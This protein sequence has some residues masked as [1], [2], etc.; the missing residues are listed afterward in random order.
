MRW[1]MREEH[2]WVER[3]VTVT[4]AVGAAAASQSGQRLGTTSPHIDKFF[5]VLFNSL[6]CDIVWHN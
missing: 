5:Q 4:A 3:P 1:G 6:L 2:R